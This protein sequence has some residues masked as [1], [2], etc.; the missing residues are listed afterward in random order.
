MKRRVLLL[1]EYSVVGLPHSSAYLRLLR[2]FTHP[3][4]RERYDTTPSPLYRGEQTEIVIV[5]R[6]W[7]PDVSGDLALELTE[8]VAQSGA[9][10]LYQ[11]D[12]D[13]LS[14]PITASYTAA[15]REAV[16]VFARKADALLVSTPLLAERMAPLNQHISIVPN[17]LDERLLVAPRCRHALPFPADGITI[18]YMGTRTH[19]A[20]LRMIL[21]ALH[22]FGRLSPHPVELQIVGVAL[23]SETWAMLASLPF[24]ARRIDPPTTEYPQFL[25]WFTGALHWDI[26][27]A[28][29]VDT[30]FNRAKSDV[31]FLD[32][33][34]L[35]AAGIYSREPVYGRSVEHGVTGWLAD[36]TTESW[37]EAL[38]TLAIQP[39]L[40]REL[41]AN[42]HRHLNEARILAHRHPDWIA[43]LEA[44]YYG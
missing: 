21:P 38:V 22:Q 17:A 44:A 20:D 25:T 19:D 24:P 11:L 43:A 3:A 26:A 16:H 34:A 39:D 2:P 31:K 12:D 27:L 18:G 40:R 5:D 15:Q 37:T 35:G 8:S 9:K 28:P 6:T 29:L 14:L 33:S 13:L 4:L 36:A 32:Y 10:L 30:P 7:R 1:Y 41:A 23:E 42:A